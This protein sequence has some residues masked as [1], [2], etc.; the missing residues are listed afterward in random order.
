MNIKIT[1]KDHSLLEEDYAPWSAH[2]QMQHLSH[3]WFVGYLKTLHQLQRL[4]TVELY[5]KV[6]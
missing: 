5:E 1:C 4:I 2:V 6:R 3:V